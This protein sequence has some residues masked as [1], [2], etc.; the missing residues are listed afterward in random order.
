MK[1]RIRSTEREKNM[2]VNYTVVP[3]ISVFFLSWKCE[4]QENV[5]TEKIHLHSSIDYILHIYC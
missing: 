5:I 4:I 3:L 1:E 2:S